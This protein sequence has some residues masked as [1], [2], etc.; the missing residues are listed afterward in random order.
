M[1]QGAGIATWKIA[2]GTAEVRHEDRVAD[3]QRIPDPVGQAGRRVAGCVHHLAVQIAYPEA[4]AILPE[5]LELVRL[6][7]QILQIED[8]FE[9]VPDILDVRADGDADLKFAAHIGRAGKMV[10][11]GM[12]FEQPGHMQIL[13]PD[14]GQYLVRALGEGPARGGVEIEH[15]IDDDGLLCVRTAG[16]IG[17]GRCPRVEKTFDQRFRQVVHG[18]SPGKGLFLLLRFNI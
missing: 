12:G 4:L 1:V 17:D 7:A 11:M 3:K 14:I 18:V 10:R 8:R 2:A 16:D 6:L 9:N 15:G 13:L 5:M